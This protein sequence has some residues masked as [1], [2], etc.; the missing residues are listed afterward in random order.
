MVQRYEATARKSGARIVRC[1]HEAP[2]LLKR[3]R[4]RNGADLTNRFRSIRPVLTEI[5]ARSA[6][7]DCELVACDEAGLPCFRTR[8]PCLTGS[9]RSQ[10]ME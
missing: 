2:P 8:S 1:R 10:A 5:P 4:S 9:D 3:R 7:I 6:I